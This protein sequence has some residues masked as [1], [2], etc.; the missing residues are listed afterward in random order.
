MIVKEMFDPPA[1]RLEQ[2]RAAYADD[3][4][5]GGLRGADRSVGVELDGH[6]PGRPDLPRLVLGEPEAGLAERANGCRVRGTRSPQPST[7][8]SSRYR[9][10]ELESTDPVAVEG[11][12]DYAGAPDFA[13]VDRV[14]YVVPLPPRDGSR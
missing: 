4:R 12:P 3:R 7:P 14:R 10:H 8:T 13:G 6:D 9:R 11:D 5:S 1:A 2:Q